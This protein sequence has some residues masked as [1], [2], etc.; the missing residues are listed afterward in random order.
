LPIAA[1][2]VERRAKLCVGETVE[3]NSPSAAPAPRSW[4]QKARKYFW[5]ATLLK[6]P[7]C[8]TKP[9]FLPLSRTRT[10]SDWFTPLDGCPR[11]GYA[12]DREPGYFLMAV[13]GVNYGVVAL[14]GLGSYLVMERYADVSVWTML[15]CLVGL[16]A[17]VSVVFARHSKAYFL[18]IDHFFDPHVRDDGSS[19]GDGGG[20]QPAAGPPPP[21]RPAGRDLP[22]TP[23]PSSD[24][25]DRLAPT[26][27]GAKR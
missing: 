18:A 22:V 26:G 8:G 19:P 15:F 3:P 23:A 14:L 9:I 20:D 16:V 6:C 27:A 17:V 21:G 13:W 2:P 1:N 4:I 25:S 5:R 24:E 11:C 10:L 12:Y 7:V